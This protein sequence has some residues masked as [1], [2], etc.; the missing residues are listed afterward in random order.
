MLL[1]YCMFPGGHHV[2]RCSKE[3]L[4]FA[5]DRSLLKMMTLARTSVLFEDVRE[6]VRGRRVEQSC[7]MSCRGSRRRQVSLCREQLSSVLEQKISDNRK[8]Q[9]SRLGSTSSKN[10]PYMVAKVRWSS[11][12]G[13]VREGNKDSG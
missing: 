7:L 6:G 3:A 13:N 9:T 11:L 1:C 5:E 8:L 10:T 4:E 12:E 2:K